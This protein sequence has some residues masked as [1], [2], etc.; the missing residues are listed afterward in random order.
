MIVKN[1]RY[2]T[3]VA[4]VFLTINDATTLDDTYSSEFFDNDEY[5]ETSEVYDEIHIS[6]DRLIY[7]VRLIFEESGFDSDI[8]SAVNNNE[9]LT[10]IDF[11]QKFINIVYRIVA[12]QCYKAKTN[13]VK[14]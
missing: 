9:E 14:L 4:C 10:D 3:L 6:L 2:L 7:D 8:F 12:L 13:F 5:T 11:T 1:S